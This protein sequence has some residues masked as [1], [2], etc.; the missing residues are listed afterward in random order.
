MYASLRYIICCIGFT[1]LFTLVQAQ[2]SARKKSRVGSLAKDIYRNFLVV[3]KKGQDS[4]FFQRSEEG[5]QPFAGK[6]IRRIIIRNLS[7]GENVNDTSQSIISSLTRTADRLQSNTKDWVIRELLFVKKG[8]L[9]DPYRL[10][11]NERFLRDQNF[12]KDARIIVR[13]VAVDSVDVYVR[14]RDVFS[15][16]AEVK[17]SGIKDFQLSVYDANFLGMA[18]RLELTGL[19]DRTRS[20]AIG[21]QI[22]YRKTSILG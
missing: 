18:Q 1:G 2:D 12:I 7:F 4:A 14:L 15:W 13:H 6:V 19:Y 21:P 9:V 20:P 5:Y 22:T 10:A 3:E 11:D 16:G 17:A 8:Q